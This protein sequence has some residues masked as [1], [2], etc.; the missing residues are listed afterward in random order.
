MSKATSGVMV[1]RDSILPQLRPAASRRSKLGPFLL[2]Q[3]RLIYAKK[4]DD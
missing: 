3:L 2:G 1:A 4:K